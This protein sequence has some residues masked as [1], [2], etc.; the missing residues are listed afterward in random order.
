MFLFNILDQQKRNTHHFCNLTT[1]LIILLLADSIFNNLEYVFLVSV[2]FS[3][4]VSLP[5]FSVSLSLSL[6]LPLYLSVSQM[7]PLY[8]TIL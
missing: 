1:F 7:R 5:L 8:Y 3:V 6:L 4:C 2:S